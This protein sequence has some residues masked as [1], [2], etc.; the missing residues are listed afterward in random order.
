M[1]PAATSGIAALAAPL[2]RLARRGSLL[3]ATDFDGTLAPVVRDPD[4]AA[5]LP[6]ARRALE[7]LASHTPVAVISARDLANLA[8]RC[9]ITGALLLGSYGQEPWLQLSSGEPPPAPPRPR[10]EL[11]QLAQE[12]SAYT[13][14]MPGVGVEAKALGVAVHYRNSPEPRRVGPLIRRQVEELCR[15]HQLQVVR[16]RQVVEARPFRSGNK[17]TALRLLLDRL[18]PRGCVYA[19]DDLGDLPAMRELH[20]QRG[21]LELAAA[22]GVG[23]S[24]VNPELV[25]EADLL[26]EGPREWAALLAEVAQGVVR[27]TGPGGR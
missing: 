9:R 26:L 12:L 5:P 24:E 8:S 21:E 18:G 4:R 13:A 11:L 17:G 3:V 14:R 27:A 16:G 23:S 2:I 15:S 6:E 20:S 10:P 22:V 19:G 25:G 1:A 7:Q